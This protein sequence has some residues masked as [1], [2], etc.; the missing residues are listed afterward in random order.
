M[1]W[2]FHK[3]TNTNMALQSLP[4]SGLLTD[5]A[6]LRALHM[7]LEGVEHPLLGSHAR[8]MGGA[9]TGERRSPTTILSRSLRSQTTQSPAIIHFSGKKCHFLPIR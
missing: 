9:W 2:A 5:Q 3:Q 8:G 6:I 4:W 1:A 7:G